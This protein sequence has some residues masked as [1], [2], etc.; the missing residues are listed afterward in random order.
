VTLLHPPA[1]SDQLPDLLGPAFQIKNKVIRINIKMLIQEARQVMSYIISFGLL[2][3]IF[4]ITDGPE[5]KIIRYKYQRIDLVGITSQ[6][7]HRIPHSCKINNRW[8]SSE[9]LERNVTVEQKAFS[10]RRSIFL[11]SSS[12]L[13]KNSCW[14]KRYLS[15]LWSCVFPINDFLNII[16]GNL[17]VITVADS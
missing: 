10:N 17:E 5:D 2:K 1:L 4:F 9:V 6:L 15:Q 14:L 7:G 13:K 16:C 12:N 11:V 3:M 8:N